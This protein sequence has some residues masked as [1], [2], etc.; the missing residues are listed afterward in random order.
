MDERPHQHLILGTGEDSFD[1]TAAEKPPND[2]TVEHPS[3]STVT[4]KPPNDTT[5]RISSDNTILEKPS[6]SATGE[7]ASTDTVNCPGG[8]ELDS[9][10]AGVC[11]SCKI[12]FYRDIN[13][14]GMTDRCQKCPEG[15]ITHELGAGKK[16]DCYVIVGERREFERIEIMCVHKD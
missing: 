13:E 15:N 4:E 5:D 14:I 11:V 3:N 1:G 12:G 2:R 9:S 7:K 16:H 8:T 6:N 10:G